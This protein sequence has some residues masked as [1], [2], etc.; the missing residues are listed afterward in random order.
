MTTWQIDPD[1]YR[2]DPKPGEVP[3]TN[4]NGRHAPLMHL[5]ARG[6]TGVALPGGW[7]RIVRDKVAP[8]AGIKPAS[9][10]TELTQMVSRRTLELIDLGDGDYNVR[11][12]ELGLAML[13]QEGVI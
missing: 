2:R 1:T 13:V 6:E 5:I 7:R 12:T 9:V 4:C 10:R 8:L 3:T 11:I